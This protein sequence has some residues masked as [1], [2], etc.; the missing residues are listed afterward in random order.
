MNQPPEFGNHT[1]SDARRIAVL[2]AYADCSPFKEIVEATHK[3]IWDAARTDEIDV[4]YISGKKLSLWRRRFNNRLERLRW[5]RLS[6][7]LVLWDRLRFRLY[8]D[9]LPEVRI[10]GRFLDIQIPSGLRYLGITVLAGSKYLIDHGYTHVLKTTVSS[11]V[12]L[13]QLRNVVAADLCTEMLYAGPVVMAPHK[14]VSGASILMNHKTVQ[15]LYKHRSLW[16]HELLDDVA[17]G[18]LL[19]GRA[20]IVA[21]DS[22]N[23]GSIEE[24]NRL[25][26]DELSKYFHFRCTS[27]KRPEGDILILRELATRLEFIRAF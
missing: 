10:S 11:M 1:S 17:M 15:Y 12:D 3:Y 6:P 14:L 13:D 21:M 20:E 23:L 18:E 7:T 22:L 25:S 19:D 27:S 2:I 26:D 16:R 9:R 5:S 24:L 4:F 8:K